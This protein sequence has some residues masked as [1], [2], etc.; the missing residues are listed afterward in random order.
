M[1]KSNLAD[2]SPHGFLLDPRYW[3]FG[4]SR[5]P[6]IFLRRTVACQLVR[7][8][9]RLPQG[10]NFKVWDAYRTYA[11]HVRMVESFRRRLACA[12]PGLDEAEREAL[13]WR[14]AARVK[15]RVTRPDSHR[16]G[17]AVDLTLVDASGR[18]LEMG[19]DHDALVPEAALAFYERKPRL[20][21][22]ERAFRD[23]RR[24]LTRA[25][26]RAGFRRYAPE[27]WHWSSIL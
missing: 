19:T 18:E 13:L 1:K 24:I 14:Y 20:S 6:R 8:R 5:S 15:R 4:W 16:T 25:M 22:R 10:W 21:P 9:E 23:R 26:T 3:C 27:W 2:L 17:G 7:A 11:T 12:N